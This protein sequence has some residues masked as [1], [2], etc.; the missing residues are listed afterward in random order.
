LSSLS[1]ALIKQSTIEIKIEIEIKIK[2]KMKEWRK[3]RIQQLIT[4][5]VDTV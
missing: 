4:E 2:I 5:N 1:L 3:R